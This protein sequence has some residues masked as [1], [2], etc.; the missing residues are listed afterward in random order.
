MS[1]LLLGIQA[2]EKSLQIYRADNQLSTH[3]TIFTVLI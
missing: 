3:P 1:L 2:A